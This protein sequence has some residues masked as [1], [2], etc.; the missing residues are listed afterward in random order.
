MT[1][2]N[3]YK[4]ETEEAT[5]DSLSLKEIAAQSFI[6]F[7]AGFETSSTTMTYALHEL[8]VNHEVQDKLRNEINECVDKNGG[9][10]TYDSIMAM[11]YMDQVINGLS[12]LNQ[13][14]TAFLTKQ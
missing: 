8:A 9:T 11:T 6:F 10:L 1:L 3:L 14:I 7:F 12:I 13:K 2:C 5:E 4:D